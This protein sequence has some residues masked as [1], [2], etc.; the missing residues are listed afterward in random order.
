MLWFSGPAM[1]R[2]ILNDFFFLSFSKENEFP[3]IIQNLILVL[4]AQNDLW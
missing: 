2:R 1:G 3:F 4:N